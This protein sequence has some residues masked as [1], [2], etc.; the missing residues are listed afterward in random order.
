MYS[1]F[2]Y[3]KYSYFKIYFLIFRSFTNMKSIKKKSLNRGFMKFRP[4]VF[5]INTFSTQYFSQYFEGDTKG[6]SNYR[7]NFRYVKKKLHFQLRLDSITHS[8]CHLMIFFVGVWG[9]TLEQKSRHS[10]SF[11]SKCTKMISTIFKNWNIV[12]KTSMLINKTLL[13]S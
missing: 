13:I 8:T 2:N 1:H 10:R 11:L 5:Y 6:H 9:Q 4:I 7:F 3:K 12:Q